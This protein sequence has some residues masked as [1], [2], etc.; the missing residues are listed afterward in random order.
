MEDNIRSIAWKR[1]TAPLLNLV[2]VNGAHIATKSN[3]ADLWGRVHREFYSL[4]E[5]TNFKEG[6]YIASATESSLRLLKDRL[7]KFVKD[8]DTAM[9]T[10]NKSAQRG[11]VM[12]EEYKLASQIIEER[13]N[14]AERSAANE[15][16]WRKIALGEQ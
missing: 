15:P 10:R 8:A 14:A 5:M 13:S 16:L 7:K 1:M 2:I 6:M 3:T 11:G 4:P 12:T 9:A